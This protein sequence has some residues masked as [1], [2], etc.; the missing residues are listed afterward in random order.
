MIRSEVVFKGRVQG[1][2]FRCTARDMARESGITGWV[3]NCPDG[4]VRLLAV[5]EES[6][7]D[8]LIKRLNDCFSVRESVVTRS[9]AVNEYTD[10]TIEY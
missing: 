5:G 2:G 6:A 10:F 1:V 3:R 9:A 8:I 7:V 4:S